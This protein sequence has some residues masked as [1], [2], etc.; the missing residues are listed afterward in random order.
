[1]QASHFLRPLL[2][3]AGRHCPACGEGRL[4]TGYLKVQPTCEVCGHD[5]GRYPAD[6]APPYFTILLIGHLV[7]APMLAFPLIW[8]W[9]AL[10]VMALTL[11]V[12][13][14][15]TLLLLPRVKGAVVGFQCA[16]AAQRGGGDPV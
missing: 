9:P 12:L 16:L 4:F 15:L 10:Q 14:I 2:R 3:G 8:K 11:P 1:M 13:V 5:N 7:V 6:D